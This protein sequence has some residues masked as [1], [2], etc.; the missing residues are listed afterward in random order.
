[1]ERGFPQDMSN[2]FPGI[3]N[4]VDAVFV[5][6]GNGKLYFIKDEFFW[7][8]DHST[9]PYVRSVWVMGPLEIYRDY[10]RPPSLFVVL[11]KEYFD[12]PHRDSHR[13]T[14]LYITFKRGG[15]GESVYAC[16]FSCCP[17][18]TPL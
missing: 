18:S 5:W 17:A 13:L 12:C 3:P 6:G 15:R 9:K 11:H 10:P 1:M 2:G 7:K 14:L 16:T 4:N 8:F